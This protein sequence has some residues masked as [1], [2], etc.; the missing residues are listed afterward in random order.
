MSTILA[1]GQEAK[2]FTRKLAEGKK[3]RLEF[4][5][6]RKDEY[7]R[8]LAYVYVAECKDCN[9][10]VPLEHEFVILNATG[11]GWGDYYTFLNATI[12]KAGY[13]QPMIIPPNVKYADLFTKLYQKARENKWGL[14]KEN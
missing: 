4:D 5:A 12:I 8:L 3:V 11:G 2:E 6:Q 13:G 7:G 9:A 1:M 14:W 10:D